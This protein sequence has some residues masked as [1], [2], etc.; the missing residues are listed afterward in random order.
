MIG[1]TNQ[2]FLN[3]S[4]IRAD[5]VVDLDKNTLT[6]PEPSKG[7][8]QQSDSFNCQKL[9]K[10]HTSFE[11]KLF[12]FKPIDRPIQKIQEK[13]KDFA[14][15]NFRGADEEDVT[16]LMNRNDQSENQL[17]INVLMYL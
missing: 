14:Q 15:F 2:L 8:I 1:T 7:K 5:I 9:I 10:T 17:R 3:F 16:G 12:Y 4:K 11:K 13:N 6:M